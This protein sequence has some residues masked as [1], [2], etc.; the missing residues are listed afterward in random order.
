MEYEVKTKQLHHWVY[1]SDEKVGICLLTG[2]PQTIQFK[3]ECESDKFYDVMEI[4]NYIDLVLKDP[5]SVESAAD[6]VSKG[7]I[8][9][10]VTVRGRSINHGWITSTVTNYGDI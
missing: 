7:F 5:V 3:L 1:E 4:E 6:S 10:K 2:E 8:D 9:Y